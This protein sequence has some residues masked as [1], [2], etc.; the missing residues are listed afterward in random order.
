MI[1]MLMNDEI[2]FLHM[3]KYIQENKLMLLCRKN[4]KD[5]LLI[6][7][8]ISYYGADNAVIRNNIKQNRSCLVAWG[9][10]SNKTLILFVVLTVFFLLQYL[11]ILKIDYKLS[12]I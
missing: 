1:F 12:N 9:V 5:L 8:K 3:P 6:W 2:I 4:K 11:A 7:Y 10:I